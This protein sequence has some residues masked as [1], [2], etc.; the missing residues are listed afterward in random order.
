[1]GEAAH[2][3]A[4]RPQ[5]HRAAHAVRRIVKAAI[6][7]AR[8]APQGEHGAVQL[9]LGT[10]ELAGDVADLLVI[11]DEERMIRG[12]RLGGAPASDPARDGSPDRLEHRGR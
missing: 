11:R 4:E 3:L 12:E 5:V 10:A 1:V 6:E 9:D 2:R 8:P 7:I